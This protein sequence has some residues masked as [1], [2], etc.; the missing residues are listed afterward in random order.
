MDHLKLPASCA[1]L[2]DEEQRTVSGGGPFMDAVDTFLTNLHLANFLW[3][4]SF[5]AFSFTFVPSLLFNVVKTGVTIVV[6]VSTRIANFLG[7]TTDALLRSV[8][9]AGSP[10]AA[11]TEP[12]S[13]STASC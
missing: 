6:D 9:E 12:S 11:P 10:S 13:D 4:N 3:G 8:L 1:F 2:S 5:I 7:T